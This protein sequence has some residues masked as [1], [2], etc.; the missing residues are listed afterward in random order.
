MG[1]I[2]KLANITRAVLAPAWSNLSMPLVR[3]AEALGVSRV[4]L[5]AH[6]EMLGLPS[7]AKNGAAPKK[8]SDAM[9]SKAWE[10]GLSR[11]EMADLFGYENVG[12]ITS[13]RRMMGL[14]PRNIGAN[15]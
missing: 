10:S 4:L 6:A 9:F 3:V 5:T 2:D 15:Q 8:C 11:Q 13:R 14:T 7:R 1:N 12:S